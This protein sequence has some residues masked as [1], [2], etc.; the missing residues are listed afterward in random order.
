MGIHRLLHF[1]CRFLNTNTAVTRQL[2]RTARMLAAECWQ[3]CGEAWVCGQRKTNQGQVLDTFG[4]LD[5]TKLR[6]VLAWSAFWNLRTFY[7][8][9][10]PNFF[11]TGVNR[12]LRGGPR[13]YCVI[14]ILFQGFFFVLLLSQAGR[15]YSASSM[16]IVQFWKAGFL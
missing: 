6:P 14:F 10:F 5:F 3:V 8:F 1:S 12:G 9:N 11:L 16:M 7:F 2:I 4:L 15:L 13:L